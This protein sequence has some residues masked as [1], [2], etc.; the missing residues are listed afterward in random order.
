M[1]L[2]HFSQYRGIR[3]Y[4]KE[5]AQLAKADKRNIELKDNI[6]PH[7]EKEEGKQVKYRRLDEVNEERV[8]TSPERKNKTDLNDHEKV[9]EEVYLGS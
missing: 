2:T 7:L 1:N 4:K 5:K 6:K 3:L 8:M 9:I